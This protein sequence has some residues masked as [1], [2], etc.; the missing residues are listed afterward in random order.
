VSEKLEV[1]RRVLCLEP[2]GRHVADVIGSP[3]LDQ[4]L[5]TVEA[6]GSNLGRSAQAEA[7]NRDRRDRAAVAGDRAA[8]QQPIGVDVTAPHLSLFDET[9]SARENA[10]ENATVFDPWGQP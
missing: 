6:G 2:K 3:D 10:L 5:P 8:A 4:G 9:G 7:R 1:G